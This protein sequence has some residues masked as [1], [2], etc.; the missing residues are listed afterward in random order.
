[1][2]QEQKQ[3]Y[4]RIYKLAIDLQKKYW[5]YEGEIDKNQAFGQVANFAKGF[6]KITLEP[7][8]RGFLPEVA[9]TILKEL[10]KPPEQETPNIPPNLKDFVLEM[11]EARAR[12]EA[13]REKLMAEAPRKTYNYFFNLNKKIISQNYPKLPPTAID[14]VSRE[15]TKDIIDKLPAVARP[16]L[17]K[18]EDYRQTIDKNLIA[19][20]LKN[21][22]LEPKEDISEKFLANFEAA[23]K[24]AAEPGIKK[25]LKEEGLKVEKPPD[26]TT[27]LP[28]EIL[29][30]FNQKPEIPTFTGLYTLLNPQAGAAFIRKTVNIVP[31]LAVKNA[32][33]NASSEAQATAGWAEIKEIARR[34]VFIENYKATTETLIRMGVPKDHP[35]IQRIED[36]IA[37]LREVQKYPLPQKDGTIIWKDFNWVKVLKRSSYWNGLV[38]K[39]EGIYDEEFGIYLVQSPEPIWSQ[40]GT[41]AYS[42]R[43]GLNKFNFIPNTSKKTFRFITGGRYES[44]GGIIRGTIYQKA[45]KPLLIRL[46]R[47]AVGK[48]TKTIFT[49]LSTRLAVKL[50]LSALTAGWATFVSFLP[51]IKRMAKKAL[52]IVGGLLLW[53]AHFGAAAVLGTLFG[54]LG[55]VIGG[56][57]AGFKIGALIGTSFSI[58]GTI[59]GAIVGFVIGGIIG[60]LGGV[61]IQ[62]LIDKI[63]AS[64]SSPL[65]QKVN[66]ASREIA[67]ATVTTSGNVLLGTV[68]VV[69]VGALIVT[70][71]TSSAFLPPEIEELGSPYIELSKTATFTGNL[72]TGENGQ[73]VYEVKVGA[74]D[75]NLIDVI[76]ND[77]FSFVCEGDKKLNINSGIESY[78]KEIEAGESWTSQ[79]TIPTDIS[80]KDCLITNRLEIIAKTEDEEEQRRSVNAIIIIGNPPSDCPH[81][82]PVDGE[83]TISRYPC[84]VLTFKG[85]TTVHGEAIDIPGDKREVLATHTGTV[86]R[87]E[88]AGDWGNVVEIT[89]SCGGK[90][91][92]SRYAHLRIIK[93][94]IGQE[95]TPRMVIGI[96]GSTGRSTGPHLHYQ[97]VGLKMQCDSIPECIKNTC[98]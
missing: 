76:I 83:I 72:E 14:E 63:K 66:I 26:K 43:Q 79:Y 25:P 41:Y 10:F 33:E 93:V 85:R 59:V 17:L 16:D 73:I 80:F 68:A 38:G 7:T 20:K 40:K 87:A 69:G 36:K 82:W 97:F 32:I 50:G 47:T 56:G 64:L 94:G 54:S 35:F 71:I 34:N 86:T 52:A 75:K 48:T 77:K 28:P 13:R 31:T 22:G 74:K 95:V 46:G 81:I 96:S 58:V 23:K 91:F 51:L 44:F 27:T 61:G 30:K 62:L 2:T 45:L 5:P 9:K 1:M 37:R 4:E 12:E 57:I 15:I 11:D 78:P 24:I 19:E 29:N 88:F 67:T 90:G 42:L 55:G 60:F 49:K 6:L 53:A 18:P 21:A 70:Q 65:L 39:T 98:P 92:V 3:D 8:D 84:E 89:G